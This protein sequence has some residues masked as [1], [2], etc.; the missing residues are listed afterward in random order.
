M[1]KLKFE[2]P[3][4]VWIN[5]DVKCLISVDSIL[6]ITNTKP[7]ILF[8]K[9]IKTNYNGSNYSKYF[10]IQE[11]YKEIKQLIKDAQ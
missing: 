6:R 9:E 4:R 10:E 11:T 7:V 1:K 5:N 8:T 3:T 2:K